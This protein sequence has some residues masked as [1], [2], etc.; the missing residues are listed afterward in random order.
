[1][2]KTLT[3]AVG[4]RAEKLDF[5]MGLADNKCEFVRAMVLIITLFLEIVK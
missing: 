1:M 5:S 2:Q 4:I 3:T